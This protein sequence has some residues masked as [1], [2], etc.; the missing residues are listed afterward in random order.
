ML[1]E[2]VLYRIYSTNP[3]KLAKCYMRAIFKPL[4]IL[5]MLNIYFTFLFQIPTCYSTMGTTL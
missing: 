4:V 3:I 1:H 2:N 5:E